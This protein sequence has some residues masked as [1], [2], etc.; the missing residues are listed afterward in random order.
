[1]HSVQCLDA[2][3]RI[4]TFFQ[5]SNLPENVF[6][7]L[8]VLEDYTLQHEITRKTKQTKITELF[9]NMTKKKLILTFG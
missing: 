1:M 3:A 4:R 2:I 5:A 9:D 7:A 6:D 8:N